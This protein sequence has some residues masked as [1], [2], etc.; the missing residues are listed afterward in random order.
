MPYLDTVFAK[1]DSRFS[2]TLLSRNPDLFLRNNPGFAN[3]NWL[4]LH[5]G[6]ILDVSSYPA[7][8]DFSYLIHA[9]TDSTNG[10]SLSPIERFEQILNGTANL[11]EFA[12]SNNIPRFLYISSGA[13]YG[14]Q[15]DN[16]PAIPEHWTGSPELTNAAN[17]YG[18]A[19]RAAEHL[20]HLYRATHGLEVVI[21]RCFAF[22][23]PALPLDVHF[24][25][26]NFIRD[27]L[28]NE[29]ITVGGDGSAIRSYLEQSDLAEWLI[30]LLLR[31][32]SGETYNVGSDQAVTIRE[33]AYL[34]R[35]LLA[36]QKSVRFLGS[37]QA[38][39]SRN[40]Y[41][42]DISKAKQDLGCDVRIPLAEAIRLTAAA[43]QIPYTAF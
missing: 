9:A 33:L 19:K 39:G 24:A 11:L 42:P 40:R 22:V 15:P 29:S 27:A 20:C 31:G 7:A 17:A 13:V 30:I 18:V 10:P 26:G 38:S 36:P 2:V 23:G 43:N 37:P 1:P 8:Q 32:V 34:V 14:T 35:D 3:Y 4:T 16:L 28:Q 25:I 12:H 5:H 6:D 21:A 41:V